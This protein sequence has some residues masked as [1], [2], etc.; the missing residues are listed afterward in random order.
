MVEK[1]A[2]APRSNKIKVEF[3]L[4]EDEIKDLIEGGSKGPK[5]L[6]V[7]QIR[8]LAEKGSIRAADFLDASQQKLVIGK[9]VKLSAKAASKAKNKLSDKTTQRVVVTE[10]ANVIADIVSTPSGSKRSVKPKE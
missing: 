10:A 3:E 8:K 2:R 9:L 6:S 5:K 7:A 4:T 1:K